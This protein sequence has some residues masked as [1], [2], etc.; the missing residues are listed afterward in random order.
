MSCT[1]Q[2]HRGRA[3]GMACGCSVRLGEKL[4]GL[5]FLSIVFLF[6]SPFM[7]TIVNPN[8]ELHEL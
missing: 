3:V 8:G 5:F 7:E 1:V 2:H 4:G 6:H